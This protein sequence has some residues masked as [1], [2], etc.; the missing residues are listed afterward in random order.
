MKTFLVS[1]FCL[2]I[3]LSM[4]AQAPVN[5]KFNLE[6]GKRYFI[7]SVS[8]QNL[9][10]SVSGQQIAINIKSNRVISF[11]L[12]DKVNDIL[13][14]ELKFDT[15]AS[16]MMYPGGSK[17]TNSTKPG[18][19]PEEKLLNKLSA[20]TLQVKINTSGKYQSL[21]NYNSFR[22]SI[23]MVLDNVSVAQKDAAK[24][25][26]EALVKESAVTSLFE[27]LFSY[28]PEKPIKV[29]DKWE[30]SFLSTSSDIS[31]IVMNNTTLTDVKGNLASFTGESAMESMPN[32]DP[33][34]VTTTDLKGTSTFNGSIDTQTGLCKQKSEKGHFAG[35]AK[36]KQGGQEYNIQLTLD[37]QSETFMFN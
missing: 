1:F 25:L 33:E 10:Q 36:T 30:N 34:A 3:S 22:D 18:D 15:I 16:S 24:K 9:Q 6:K 20:L 4:F 37:S 19:L 7:K 13:T 27:P 2:L 26:A 28:L 8:T 21:V 11:R 32:T 23:L 12:I 35:S 5:V 17:E 29:G 14:L 31:F